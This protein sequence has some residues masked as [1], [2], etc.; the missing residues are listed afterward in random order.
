MVPSSARR[1][2]TLLLALA[3]V[4]GFAVHGVQAAQMSATMVAAAMDAPMPDG[5]DA[6]DKDGNVDPACTASCAGAVAILPVLLTLE[7]VEIAPPHS[8]VGVLGAGLHGPPDPFPPRPTA[9]I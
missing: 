9:L 4:V 6:C 7:R 1:L 3:L 8:V 5:C 2:S